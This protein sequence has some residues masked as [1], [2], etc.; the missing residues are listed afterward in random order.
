MTSSISKLSALLSEKVRKTNKVIEENLEELFLCR[1]CASMY[2][3]ASM[4][5]GIALGEMGPVFCSLT[6]TSKT[7]RFQ[8]CCFLDNSFISSLSFIFVDLALRLN[9]FASS[10][11]SF[12]ESSLSSFRMA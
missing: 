4:I 8:I 5:L 9:E 12:G 1:N 2:S 6:F 11:I 10:H 7:A 3:N